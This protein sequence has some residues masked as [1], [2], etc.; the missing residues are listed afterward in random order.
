MLFSFM[1]FIFTTLENSGWMRSRKNSPFCVPN[2]ISLFQGMDVTNV[3]NQVTLLENVPMQAKVVC[4][5]EGGVQDV[6]VAEG[7]VGA[8]L[9]MDLKASR[10][11][12][13]V[14]VVEVTTLETGLE[15]LRILY[16]IQTR[17]SKEN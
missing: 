1:G 10:E 8:A 16:S 13:V 11:I 3:V 2:D 12:L 6:E 15:K 9:W 17:K 14:V 5:V 7:V 4:R